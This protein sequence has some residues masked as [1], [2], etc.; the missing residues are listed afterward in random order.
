MRRGLVTQ[1]SRNWGNGWHTDQQGNSVRK[2]DKVRLCKWVL[3]NKRVCVSVCLSVCQGIDHFVQKLCRLLCCQVTFYYRPQRSC[4]SYVF[5]GVCLST[6]GGYLI[7]YTPL[8]PGAPPRPGTHPPVT[9]Y[10]PPDQVHPP[11]DQIR[12]LLRTVRILLE[13]ILVNLVPSMYLFANISPRIGLVFVSYGVVWGLHFIFDQI[14]LLI[15][16]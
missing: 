10:T 4:E 15:G 1:L 8:G 6:G 12:S 5:K 14:F 9:R 16:E 13:C 2:C 7:R 3:K 11:R